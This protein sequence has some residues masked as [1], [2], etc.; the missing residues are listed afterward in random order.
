[1]RKCANGAE[2]KRPPSAGEHRPAYVRGSG[3]ICSYCSQYKKRHP[4]A[5]PLSEAKSA[6]KN[7]NRARKERADLVLGLKDLDRDINL[8]S[9]DE[10][11]GLAEGKILT[12]AELFRVIQLVD[13]K[14]NL[15]PTIAVLP[16][17]TVFNKEWLYL[18][19][20]ETR[21][22]LAIEGYFASPSEL[23]QI[24]S[25]RRTAPEIFNY[26]NTAQFFYELAAE[27]R[28]DRSFHFSKALVRQVHVSLFRG[29]A[30]RGGELRR[31]KIVISGARVKPPEND[32]ESYI[33]A[34]LAIVAD[35]HEQE[36][37]LKLAGAFHVLFESMHPFDDGNGRAGRILMNYLLVL[38]GY[39]PVT[40]KGLRKEDREVYYQ[41]LQAADVGFHE[42]FPPVSTHLSGQIAERLGRGSINAVLT[43]L[44]GGQ[45][46]RIDDLLARAVEGRGERLIPLSELAEVLGAKEGTLRQWILRGK[47]VAIRRGRKLVSHKLLKIG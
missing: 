13:R 43:L 20:E 40:I 1:M 26:Y 45:E 6:S 42:G 30:R 31:G 8:A 27:H 9:D 3:D 17:P 22:S 4:E 29:T 19:E 39:Q 21:N 11:N 14:A 12:D 2:C 25:G 37:P 24:L 44:V 18:L 16:S 10:D 38:K 7:I 35:R 34:L 32:I 5:G 15:L 33:D 46:S 36:H 41:A 23:K 47:L 28:R